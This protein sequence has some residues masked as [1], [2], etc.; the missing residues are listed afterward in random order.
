M[1]QPEILSKSAKRSY[2]GNDSR[3]KYRLSGRSGAAMDPV[4]NRYQ[5]H[6]VKLGEELFRYGYGLRQLTHEFDAELMNNYGFD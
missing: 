2:Y 3:L 6:L 1:N 4:I 5:N